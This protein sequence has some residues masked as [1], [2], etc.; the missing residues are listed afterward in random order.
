MSD[1]SKRDEESVQLIG[2]KRQN[3]DNGGPVSKKA[4]LTDTGILTNFF[5]IYFIIFRYCANKST[6]SIRCCWC[7]N[8]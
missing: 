1:D 5:N 3:T 6:Y 2:Q 4:N 7:F 8:R